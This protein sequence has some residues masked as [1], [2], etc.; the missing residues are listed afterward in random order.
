MPVGS[1]GAFW[2]ISY[3]WGVPL[4]AAAEQAYLEVY[5]KGRIPLQ[6]SLNAALRAL[7][8]KGADIALWADA[9]CINQHDLHKK[10]LQIRLGPR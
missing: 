2:T 10:A 7:R 8:A 6:P 9:V 3:F 5:P 4:G 1:P